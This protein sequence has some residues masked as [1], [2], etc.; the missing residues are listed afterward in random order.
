MVYV[1]LPFPPIPS[2]LLSTFPPFLIPR[3]SPL[4]IFNLTSPHRTHLHL[5]SFSVLTT[6][7][8]SVINCDA[9]FSSGVT[10]RPIA[11]NA[12][13]WRNMKGGVGDRRTLHAGLPVQRGRKLG[14]NIW[15]REG[16]LDGV[17]RSA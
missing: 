6:P 5:S 12:V 11:R 17:Y 4:L 16:V 8:G 9:P 3:T 2:S 10:F 13:F 14:M 7:P 1:P 15:T